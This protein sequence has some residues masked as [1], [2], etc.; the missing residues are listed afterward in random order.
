MRNQK[1]L[2]AMANI[3][4]DKRSARFHCVLV[5]MKSHLDP[6]PIVAHA[7]W[8]GRILYAPEGEQG[9][10]YDPVFYVPETDCSAASLEASHK[11]A[12]SHRGQ[13]LK[14]LMHKLQAHGVFA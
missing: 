13:A 4:E 11:N 9:M 6:S 2:D 3:D 8:E 5:Y 12:I 7:T 14:M 10:G 1:L